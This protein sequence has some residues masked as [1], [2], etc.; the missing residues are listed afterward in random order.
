MAWKGPEWAGRPRG[1]FGG[2]RLLVVLGVC[3]AAVVSPGDPV[4]AQ[5]AP[6]TLGV[7]AALDAQGVAPDATD[8]G[9]KRFILPPFHSRNSGS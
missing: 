7:T 3:A 4:F 2:E 9:T 6:Y 8:S 5:A 1:R